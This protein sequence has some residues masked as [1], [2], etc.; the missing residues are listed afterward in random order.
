MRKQFRRQ[1]FII[2]SRTSAA[3]AAAASNRGDNH[4]RDLL[5][6]QKVGEDDWVEGRNLRVSGGLEQSVDLLG[7]DVGLSKVGAGR[8]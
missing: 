5:R 6:A 7:R 2:H 8:R 3:A 4:L 1:V